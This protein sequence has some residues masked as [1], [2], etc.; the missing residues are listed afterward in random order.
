MKECK[1]IGLTGGVGSGKTF[2]ALR[3]QEKYGVPVLFADEIGHL[4]L[5]PGTDTYRKVAAAF[6]TQILT[7]DG[8]VD[9]KR[10]GDLVFADSQKLDKLN[11]IVH[12]FIEAYIETEIKR[13]RKE[14]QA[15][16]ILLEAAILLESRL[17]N[18][19]DEIWMV[20]A[21]DAFR[22]ERLKA[23]RGYTEQKINAIMQ[24][25][26]SG[27]E[28]EKRVQRVIINSGNLVEI[29]RQLEILLV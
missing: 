21:D 26:L 24:V 14:T 7:P 2:I 16:H 13:L 5:E 25:Q 28:I 20:K 4:A 9:R 1:I 10:L 3:A 19:C 23:S 17:V 6:G 27:Q 12:P 15:Q 18:L 22:R 11:R 29:D 8:A